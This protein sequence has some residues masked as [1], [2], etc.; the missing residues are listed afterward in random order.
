MTSNNQNI[1][2]FQFELLYELL[3]EAL[4]VIDRMEMRWTPETPL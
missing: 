3:M 1:C 2:D 4:V